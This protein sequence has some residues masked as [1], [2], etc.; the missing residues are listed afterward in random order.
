[1]AALQLVEQAGFLKAKPE[2]VRGWVAK[3]LEASKPFGERWQREV[4]LSL[5]ELLNEQDGMAAVTVPFARQAERMLAP[6]D[7]PTMHK[8][9][10]DALVTA[11]QRNGKADEAKEVSA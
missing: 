2:D 9:T 6:K 4:L 3:A 8:R 1:K 7:R 5:V 11:L 10:L